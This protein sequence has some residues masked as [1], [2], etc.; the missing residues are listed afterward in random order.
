MKYL[1]LILLILWL[2]VAIGSVHAGENNGQVA[3]SHPSD[4]QEN[5]G[6]PCIEVLERTHHFGK[7]DLDRQYEHEFKVHNTG[8]GVL[9]IEKVV[10][11]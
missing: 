3:S 11:G 9:E 8:T 6:T 10:V 5:E 4:S 7:L 2:S 1:F